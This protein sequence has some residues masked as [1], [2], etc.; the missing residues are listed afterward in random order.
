MISHLLIYVELS[1][2]S[3]VLSCSPVSHGS[4]RPTRFDL[5]SLSPFY[6]HFV[7]SV[8]RIKS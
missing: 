3:T 1:R 2:F 5:K 7:G 4:S 6:G 8:Y